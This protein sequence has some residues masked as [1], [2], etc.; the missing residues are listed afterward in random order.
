MVTTNNNSG[1]SLGVNIDHVATIR[2]ARLTTYPD[3]YEAA[4]L[5]KDGGAD[6]I[7]VHL[8]EDRRHIQDEDVIKLC[9]EFDLPI[10]LEMAAT[11]EMVAIATRLKPDEC[12]LVPEH[13]EELT[14]EGGLNILSQE[15]ELTT[16][17]DKLN[18]AGIKVS[19]FID[20]DLEQIDAA[21][22]M[23]VPVVELHTGSYADA[24]TTTQREQE[25]QRI[26]LASIHTQAC[27]IQLNAG[28]GLHYDNVQPIA[29]LPGMRCLNIGHSIIARAIKVGLT[30]AVSDMIRAMMP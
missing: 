23:G 12:C 21:K 25:Y 1:L 27:G 14:T 2:Q 7:T 20:P 29:A 16:V 26:K 4:T 22:R 24:K 13:R 10:N 9:R 6:S 28:H 11:R 5:C 18:C 15:N 30:Q 3:I 8:R 17:C 19:L